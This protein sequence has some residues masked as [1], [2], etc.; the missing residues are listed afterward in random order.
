MRRCVAAGLATAICL[1]VASACGPRPEKASA[2]AAPGQASLPPLSLPDLS[3][4]DA[5]V[6][7]QLRQQSD[8]RAYGEV[9]RLLMAAE[10]FEAAA[11]YLLHAQAQ[12]PE[13]VR[14]P[15]YLGHVHMAN[16]E[17]GKAVR[18]FQR[19]LQLQP[20]DVATLVWL[21]GVHLD[22]GQ[23]ELAEPLYTRALVIQPRAVSALFGLGQAALARRE[24][25]RAVDQF[26]QALAADPR[27]SIAHYPL[28]LAYRS[29]GNTAQAEAH[30]RQQ[31]RVEVGPPDPLMTEIRGLLQGPVAEEN[32]GIRA[33]DDGDFKTAAEHF[34]RGLELA[35]DNPSL[36]HKLGTALSLAGDTSGAFEQFQETIKRTP[37]FAQAYYSLG[38]LLA[39]SGRTQE[40]TER[41]S[42]AVRYQ[43]D[44]VEAPLR[45]AE[46]L[47]QIGTAACRESV[48]E[49]QW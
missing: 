19:A 44:Y 13:D 28:A 2:D 35:P 24:Y 29:L 45:H 36:R 37:D 25:A 14:W 39:I 12:A 43:P 9:G 8:A 41:F 46:L 42:A 49:P 4:M 31:G 15:Y 34:R 23:P 5:A 22:Q 38:V 33:M 21:A 1:L 17:P 26:E 7:A 40:A 48:L 27:E 20:N 32:R 11:P 3:D 47:R 18:A 16:A 30:L 6:Q 10:Y